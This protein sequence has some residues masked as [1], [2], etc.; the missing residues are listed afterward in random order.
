MFRLTPEAA[1]RRRVIGIKPEISLAL[2][3]EFIAPRTNFTF[4]AC[5]HPK[6]SAP[7]LDIVKGKLCNDIVGINS[8]R[9]SQSMLMGSFGT[10]VG[11]LHS[12]YGVQ[13]T[14]PSHCSISSNTPLP[15][16][17]SVK[18]LLKPLKNSLFTFASVRIPRICNV[19]FWAISANY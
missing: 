2:A 8:L 11:S 1:Q 9:R 5:V 4:F 6:I 15:H 12:Q 10:H 17:N 16:S 7:Y 19:F 18:M 14:P 3:R 13:P